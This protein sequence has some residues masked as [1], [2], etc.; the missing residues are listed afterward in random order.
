LVCIKNDVY[1]VESNSNRYS[2]PLIN[3]FYS[4]D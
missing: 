4:P 2:F 1:P 3:Y